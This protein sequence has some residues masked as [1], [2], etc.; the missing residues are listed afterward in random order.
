MD[1]RQFPSFAYKL[2]YEPLVW[3]YIFMLSG[4]YYKILHSDQIWLNNNFPQNKLMW[5]QGKVSDNKYTTERKV[6]G[7]SGLYRIHYSM[8]ERLA[9][10]IYIYIKVNIRLR[11]IV[12]ERFIQLKGNLLQSCKMIPPM[13]RISVAFTLPNIY[14]Y[15]KKSK[16]FLLW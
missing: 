15:I 2:E 5:L 13:L 4:H 14:I 9:H 8:T 12:H 10:L 3:A 11:L 6:L 16:Y 1:Q 7:R